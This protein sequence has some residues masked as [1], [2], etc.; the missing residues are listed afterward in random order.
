MSDSLRS[1]ALPAGEGARALAD[2]KPTWRRF[3]DR[4]D[5]ILEGDH[6]QDT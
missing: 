4:V 2:F 1:A 3:A 6:G 5:Q